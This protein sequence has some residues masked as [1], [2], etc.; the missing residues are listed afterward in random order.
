MYFEGI[1]SIMA[2]LRNHPL[3]KVGGRNKRVV[4]GRIV[5]W[6]LTKNLYRKTGKIIS[7]INDL[8]LVVIPGRASSTGNYYYGLMEYEQM[9]F[10]FHYCDNEDVFFDIGANIGAYSVLVSHAGKVVCFE[11]AKDTIGLLRQNIKINGID[12]ATV[13][14]K[15]VSDR[16]GA[17]L[18]TTGL[19]STNHIT[20][21]E[22]EGT[23]SIQT[24][25]LDSF[26]EQTDLF[27]TAIKIDA[28]GAEESIILGAS[29][30]LSD[31]RVNVIVMEIFG[32][33]NRSNLVEQ[34]GFTLYAYNPGTKELYETT[35][36]EAGRNGI[37]IR[38]AE[39]A[40]RKIS[41]GESIWYAGVK[42]D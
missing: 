26:T 18:F 16:D 1:Y 42:L 30:V 32:D 41:D 14:D 37:F 10:L 27:P 38:N 34:F 35:A 17:L 7:W 8:Q 24:V 39:L 13:I 33:E 4:L 22:S 19:D 29:K 23:V 6:Q 31:S 2:G 5:K 9:A 25:K 21:I 12:N 36:Q 40:K 28:E 3:T 15:G 11:P 20:D